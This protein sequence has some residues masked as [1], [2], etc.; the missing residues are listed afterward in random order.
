MLMPGIVPISEMRKRQ[1]EVLAEIGRRPVVLT[2]HGRGVA[3]LVSLEEWERLLERLEDLDDAV[4][5]LEAREQDMEPPAGL[6]Q[7]L[8][9]S[10]DKNVAI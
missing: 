6:E 9:Q 4:T 1:A 8:E 2:Q 3:V 10:R 5:T 7:A